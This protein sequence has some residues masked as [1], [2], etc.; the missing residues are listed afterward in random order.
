[1]DNQEKYHELGG[2]PILEKMTK[3]FYDKVYDHPW[4]GKFFN[5]IKQETIES[6]QVDFLQGAL[7]G[8]KVYCGQ[9]PIPAHKHMFI[10]EELYELRTKLL[11][12]A[13]QE[14]QASETLINKLLKID[15]S[16]KRGLVKQSI[17]D[18][19]KRFHSDTLL[20]FEKVET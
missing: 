17:T 15:D 2:R 11:V 10:T 9:L 7:G 3:A 16:F 19:E 1:M 20:N 13:L 4:L 8:P 18:C 6:Q 14:V 5:G 12:E